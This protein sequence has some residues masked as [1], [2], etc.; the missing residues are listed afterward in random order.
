MAE[1][2]RQRRVMEPLRGVYVAMGADGLLYVGEP[3]SAVR[4]AP[5]LSDPDFAEGVVRDYATISRDANGH[6]LIANVQESDGPVTV[7]KPLHRTSPP[8]AWVQP[9]RDGSG[10]IVTYDPRDWPRK[11]DPHSPRS[12]QVLSVGLQATLF[13]ASR[14]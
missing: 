4:V 1:T 8:G 3:P 6:V 2:N 10:W 11:G 9:D 13:K 14:R 12:D 7:R 5:D